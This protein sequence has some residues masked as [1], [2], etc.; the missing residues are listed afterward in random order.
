MKIHEKF[1]IGGEWVVPAGTA[2]EDVIN[3]ATEEVIGRVPMG[4]AEDVDRA[5]AAARRVSLLVHHLTGRAGK[6]SA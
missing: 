5:V 4:S 1:Y 6:I 3:S 2:T